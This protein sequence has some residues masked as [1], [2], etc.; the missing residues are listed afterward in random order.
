MY[1]L[2]QSINLLTNQLKSN[3][4]KGSFGVEGIEAQKSSYF[5][6]PH[7]IKKKKSPPNFGKKGGSYHPHP[8]TWK[9]E[10]WKEIDFNTLFKNY[11][12]KEKTKNKLLNE[13]KIKM[14]EDE[15]N[16]LNIELIYSGNKSHDK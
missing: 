14:K 9:Q 15:K 13:I 1:E 12:I 6:P 5:G 3:S 10:S 7:N 8:K 11:G 4:N 2:S 16:D